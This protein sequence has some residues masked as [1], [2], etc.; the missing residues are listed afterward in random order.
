MTTDTTRNLSCLGDA[1]HFISTFRAIYLNNP[2]SG[3]FAGK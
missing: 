3:S 2:E 1:G